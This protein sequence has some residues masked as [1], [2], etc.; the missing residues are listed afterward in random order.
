MFSSKRNVSVN[1]FLFFLDKGPKLTEIHKELSKLRDQL[2]SSE[3]INEYLRKELELHDITHGNAESLFEMAQKLNL[4][5]EELEQYKLKLVKVREES[6]TLNVSNLANSLSS[7]LNEIYSNQDNE[8]NVPT[9]N[10]K[11][12]VATLEKELEDL[13]TKYHRLQV[14]SKRKLF[15]S[16]KSIKNFISRIG[17]IILKEQ[18][19]TWPLSSTNTYRI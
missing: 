16:F 5:K 4:T 9:Q 8:Q 11:V 15:Y 18:L 17:T 3:K 14:N 7:K 19:D 1:K 13:K 6:K 10:I 2:K 12:T